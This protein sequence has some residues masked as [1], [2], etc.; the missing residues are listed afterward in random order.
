MPILGSFPGR[1]VPF[2]PSASS[3]CCSTCRGLWL[4]TDLKIE[5]R[6][7]PSVKEI[8]FFFFTCDLITWK[9]SLVYKSCVYTSQ[10]ADTALPC[11][12]ITNV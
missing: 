10:W 1:A 5:S 11:S 7:N 2:C 8:F 6:S 4:V 9:E 3:W 12:V